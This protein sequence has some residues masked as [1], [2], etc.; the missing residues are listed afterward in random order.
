MNLI[1][2][3]EVIMM[4]WKMNTITYMCLFVNRVNEVKMGHQDHMEQR[5]CLVVMDSLV[6]QV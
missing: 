5:G 6:P 2:F 3:I 1:I 4:V